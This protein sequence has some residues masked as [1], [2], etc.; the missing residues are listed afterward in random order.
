MATSKVAPPQHSS[1][2]R[3]RQRMRVI[4]RDGQHVGSAH[5]RGEQRLVGVAHGGVGQQYLLLF[6]HPLRK[7]F[8]PERLQA[9]AAARRDRARWSNR[10]QDRRRQDGRPACCAPSFQGCR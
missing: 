5:A 3:L 7:S 9:V 4:R 8:R 6:A 2:N 10:R 1:E